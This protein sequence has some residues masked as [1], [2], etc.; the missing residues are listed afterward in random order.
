MN[1]KNGRRHESRDVRLP[2]GD[3]LRN[4]FISQMVASLVIVFILLSLVDF[5]TFLLIQMY[6]VVGSIQIGKKLN[7]MGTSVLMAVQTPKQA[8]IFN[9]MLIFWPFMLPIMQTRLESMNSPAEE[10]KT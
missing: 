10:K 7:L 6:I 1:G 8:F 4:H 9:G 3:E 2:T 5:K